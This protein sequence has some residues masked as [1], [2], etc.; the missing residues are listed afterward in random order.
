MVEEIKKIAPESPDLKVLLDVF[1]RALKKDINCCNIGT[2]EQFYPETQTADVRFALTQVRNVNPDGT[3]ILEERPVL[4]KVPVLML[5]GGGSYLT[6]PIAPGD[7]CLLFFNDRQFD[8]WFVNGGIQIPNSSRTHDLSDGFAFVGIKNLQNSISNYLANGIRLAYDGNT[9]IDL[10][11][12]AINS[13][14]SLWTHTG[15]MIITGSLQAAEAHIDNGATGT[16][17]VV[18]VV[19]GIVTGGS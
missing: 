1:G 4:L 15:D 16:F 9:K 3:K 12:G 19:D 14:A 10:T 8:N 7:D 5:Y 17:D 18:T 6:F 2:V 13:L 11:E